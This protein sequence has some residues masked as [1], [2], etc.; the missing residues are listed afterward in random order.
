M[1]KRV[2]ALGSGKQ[3]LPAS[4]HACVARSSSTYSRMISPNAVPK[5]TAV[6]TMLPK[7]MPPLR[8]NGYAT[9]KLTTGGA[10]S[11]RVIQCQLSL[12]TGTHYGA[13]GLGRRFSS[14][15]S[16]RRSFQGDVDLHR[17][18]PSAVV[19]FDI[20]GIGP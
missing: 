10:V 9:I 4:R 3:A 6:P 5:M 11:I 20:R 12:S 15:R 14:K 16:S 1:A 7:I 8:Q 13:H 18:W 2:N 19:T 17:R